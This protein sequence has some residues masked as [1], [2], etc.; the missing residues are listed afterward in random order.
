MTVVFDFDGTLT[1]SFSSVALFKHLPPLKAIRCVVSLMAQKVGGRKDYQFLL[2]NALK[3]TDLSVLE[4]VGRRL[5]HQPHGMALLRKFQEEGHEVVVLSYG[6]KPVIEAFMEEHG[7][8]VPVM[9][10]D[11]K[12]EEGR[13]C[14]PADDP[15][16]HLMLRDAD[17]A[18]ARIVRLLKLKPGFSVGDSIR[19]D[20]L[21]DSYLDIRR[22]QGPFALLRQVVV[23]LLG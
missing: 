13:V 4:Q 22:F 11:L 23:S 16:T 18:K 15:V 12:Y 8:K 20:K 1:N 9:A 3:G 2:V 14:G 17:D 6:L 19:R 7:L 5:P 21:S 10:I